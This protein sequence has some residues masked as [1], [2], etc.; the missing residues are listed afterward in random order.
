MVDLVGLM[1]LVLPEDGGDVA[2]EGGG[3]L[4]GGVRR[5]Q[6]RMLPSTDAVAAI[7]WVG[8]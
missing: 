3:A 5:F 2:L 8:D 4:V 6:K 7:P 1:C